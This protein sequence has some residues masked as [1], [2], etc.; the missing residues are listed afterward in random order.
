[1]REKENKQQRVRKFFR[2]VDDSM[3]IWKGKEGVKKMEDRKKGI[4]L[5]REVEKEKKIEFLSMEISRMR[6]D[7]RIKIK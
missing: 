7:E 4:L 1:M 5:D 2:Q 3:R 6:E